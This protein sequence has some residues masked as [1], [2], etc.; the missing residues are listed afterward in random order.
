M[1]LNFI[2]TFDCFV[3]VNYIIHLQYNSKQFHIILY[4]EEIHKNQ[5][6]VY[7]VTF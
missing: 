3:I 5:K 6:F 1:L 7:T 4:K 2:I